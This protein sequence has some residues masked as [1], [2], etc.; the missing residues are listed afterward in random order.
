M[1]VKRLCFGPYV[2]LDSVFLLATDYWLLTT[3]CR[4]YSIYKF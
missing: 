2:I 1:Y 3:I 4:T